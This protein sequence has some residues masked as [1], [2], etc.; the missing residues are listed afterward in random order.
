MNRLSF[1]MVVLAALACGPHITRAQQPPSLNQIPLAPPALVG[2]V[3]NSGGQ[4]RLNLTNTDLLRGFRGTAQISLGNVTEQAEAGQMAVALAPEESHLFPLTA[5]TASGDQYAL[6]IYDQ[7]GALVFY[8]VAPIKRL[9]DETKPVATAVSET[10]TVAVAP[11]SS[12]KEVEVKP[13]LAGG[14]SETAPFVLAFEVT[15]QKP[16]LN[17]TLSVNAKGFQQRQIVNV[18][19]RINVEFKLPDELEERKVGYTLTNAA[20]QVMAQG[21]A[22]LDQLLT[23]DYISV[24]EVKLDRP[25]Y[26]LGETA[27]VTVALQGGAQRS[28]RLEVTARDGRGNIFFRD[29]RKGANEGGKSN[30]E[31]AVNLPRETPGPLIFEFKLYEAETGTLFDSG[32][33]EIA[34]TG[35]GGGV[36]DTR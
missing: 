3:E 22:D 34:L 28:F 19:G 35:T 24:S 29:S 2:S 9:S 5:L 26:A 10:A 23:N 15:A 1:S 8:K 30:Q 32:E 31:F 17:A 33:R 12:A 18:Q 7:N 20:G 27:R 16:L 6:R 36:S 21:E 4:L 14:E 25:A 11:S 13:R